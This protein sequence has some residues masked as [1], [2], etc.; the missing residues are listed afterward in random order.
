MRTQSMKNSS[1]LV[2]YLLLGIAFV[3]LS[4]R[5]FDTIDTAKSTVAVDDAENLIDIGHFALETYGQ[6]F[7]DLV[8]D[9]L[10]RKVDDSP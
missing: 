1:W 5:V 9:I 4:A 7:A 8:H 10:N 6:K 3:H 2:I